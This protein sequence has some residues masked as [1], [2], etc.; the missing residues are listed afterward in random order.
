VTG[1]IRTVKPEWLDD[2]RLAA[3]EDYVRVLSVGL[4]LLADDYGRGRAHPLFLASHVWPYTES[5]EALRRATAGLGQLHGWF[6]DLYE[7][8]GQQYFS[9]RN[10]TRHQRVQHP[11]APR[12]PLPKAGRPVPV[13]GGP[14]ET[15]QES[16]A[17]DLRSPIT[18]PDQDP[19]P[20]QDLSKDRSRGTSR[21]R[22]RGENGHT[23]AEDVPS[24][25]VERERH[26]AAIRAARSREGETSSFQPSSL[27]G[28]KLVPPD[29]GAADG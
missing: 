11:S 12:V 1:R 22:A 13:S 20:D 14:T 7:V 19:D 16:L 26:L 29:D 18:D 28:P 3:E 21:R 15:S 25:I 9:V 5:H 23:D 27:K 10:W 6:V 2:E 4:I 24:A 8:A 17:P